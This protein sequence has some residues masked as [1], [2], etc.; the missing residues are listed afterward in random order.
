MSAVSPT[1]FA[2]LNTP[3]P[4]MANS[5]GAS[6]VTSCLISRSRSFT[7]RIRSRHGDSLLERETR[8]QALEIVEAGDDI[9]DAL[10]A[11]QR[12]QRRIPGSVELVEMPPQSAR[13]PGAFRHQVVTMIHQ[14]PH[15]TRWAIKLRSWQVRFLQRRTRDRQRVDRIGLARSASTRAGCAPSSSAA[16]ARSPHPQQA[17]RASN[18]R[19]QMPAVLDRP[20]T[21]RAEL[22]RP[23]Q[24]VE[25][26]SR[27]R[28]CRDL[29][30][31]LAADVEST[32]T[33][34]WVRLCASIP[35]TNMVSLP[36]TR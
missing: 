36:F 11:V 25:M 14:Q 9:V 18:R 6:S 29:L 21:F 7:R 19:E 10:V 34:V 16:P 26:I 13:L 33:T 35:S 32:A 27:G 2:A 3:Q 30:A 28:R 15:L 12:L 23:T 20:A 17:G 22:L 1:I 5:V 4:S 31:Q 8:D 24:H